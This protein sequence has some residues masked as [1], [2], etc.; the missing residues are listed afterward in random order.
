MTKD[1]AYRIIG[2]PR[3]ANLK[4]AEMVYQ[5]KCHK[6]RFRVLPGN[7]A[8]QRQ[9]ALGQLVELANA[10]DT[11]NTKPSGNRR[12]S[13]PPKTAATPYTSARPRAGSDYSSPRN[14]SG[15]WDRFLSLI[16][17]SENAVAFVMA[18]VIILIVILMVQISKGV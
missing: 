11:V 13:I 9:R 10:W 4:K 7:T 1:D 17:L 3:S 6:L 8:T 16:P 12:G 15:L 14:L 5:Q 18:M 2:V